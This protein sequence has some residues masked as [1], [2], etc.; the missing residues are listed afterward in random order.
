[1][2]CY[3][4]DLLS[5]HIHYLVFCGFFLMTLSPHCSLLAVF[6]LRCVPKWFPLVKKNS[7]SPRSPGSKRTINGSTQIIA[8]KMAH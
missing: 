2:T 7:D 4:I 3:Y 5:S 6:S 1:M 8:I